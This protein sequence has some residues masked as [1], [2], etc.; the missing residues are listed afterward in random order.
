MRTSSNVCVAGILIRDGKV[1][2]VRRASWVRFF[3]GA[4]DLFGGHVNDGESL[5][6]ALR[7]EAKEE[8]GIEELNCNWLGQVVDPVEP[9][10]IHV[11]VIQAWEGEPANA[12]PEEHT[13]LRWFSATELPESEA[14]DAYRPL[15]VACLS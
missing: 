12:A 4:W 3:P 6:K 2:L 10:T 11:Y 9:A 14:L 1:L 13:E 8:L 5:E 7:R 15:I